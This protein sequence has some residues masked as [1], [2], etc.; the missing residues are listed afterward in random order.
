MDKTKVLHSWHQFL[1]QYHADDTPKVHNSN[2]TTQSK[3]SLCVKHLVSYK[4]LSSISHFVESICAHEE[5]QMQKSWDLGIEKKKPENKYNHPLIILCNGVLSSCARSHSQ[6]VSTLPATGNVMDEDILFLNFLF[7]KLRNQE[8]EQ[9]FQSKPP[10]YTSS[11]RYIYT[12]IHIYIN[13]DYVHLYTITIYLTV[14]IYYIY[15]TYIQLHISSLHM[16]GMVLHDVS[17][18]H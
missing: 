14:Y 11:M 3:I 9:S 10:Q 7:F 16:H 18:K 12:C 8:N 5:M 1:I 6:F 13:N 17:V 2:I 15:Y 4:L